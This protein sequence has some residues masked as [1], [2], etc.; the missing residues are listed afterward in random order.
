MQGAK[1]FY[2]Q[3][4]HISN[5]N[6][7]VIRSRHIFNDLLPQVDDELARHLA[8]INVVPQVFLLRWIRLLFGRE[9]S[10]DDMLSMWD[11]IFAEDAS[12]ELVDNI[13]VA[14]LLRIRWEL[15]EADYNTALTILLRYPQPR[16]DHPGQTF[17]FDALYLRSHMTVEGG[18]Y[19]VLKY[20][21]RPL[22]PTHRPLTPPALQRNITAFSGANALKAVSSLPR[23]SSRQQRN[24]EAMF[25]STAQNIY[26]RGERLGIGKAVRSAVSEVQKKAQEIRDTPAPSPPTRRSGGPGRVRS[27]ESKVRA[28]EARNKQLSGLLG[29]AVSELW[30]HQKLMSDT[31]YPSA[32]TESADELEKL[33]LAIAKVQ[34]VQVYL[35]DSSL[36]LP[37]AEDADATENKRRERPDAIDIESDAS[38]MTLH[39]PNEDAAKSVSPFGQ[40][41]P[42]TSITDSNRDRGVTDFGLV[43]PDAFEDPDMQAVNH[44]SDSIAQR[45]ATRPDARD[46]PATSGLHAARPSLA[47][48]SYSWMLGQEETTASPPTRRV[49]PPAEPITQR[50]FLFGDESATTTMVRPAQRGVRRKNRLSSTSAASQVE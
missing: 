46:A 16:S 41:A 31:E 3:T 42:Q 5:D 28:L 38:S 33:S 18:S 19:L 9:F 6:P 2:E 43:D 1:I 22:Q 29:S 37:E 8:A 10:F 7:I 49:A 36:P 26:S 21:D 25:H 47:Q 27:F 12:L 30:A 14:M 11:I 17:V 44:D 50:R 48:S 34:F 15:L 39:F 20:T 24:I 13:C 35:E 40:S 23:P 4:T 32:G 45:D